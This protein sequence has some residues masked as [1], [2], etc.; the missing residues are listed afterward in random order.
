M[1]NLSPIERDLLEAV[2]TAPLTW[3]AVGR[4]IIIGRAREACGLA[5]AI[6]KQR[7]DLEAIAEKCEERAAKLR[8]MA[9]RWPET[10][11]K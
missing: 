8:A 7:P 6:R 3:E 4:Q 10:M 5:E 2:E 11:R 1:P 9:E